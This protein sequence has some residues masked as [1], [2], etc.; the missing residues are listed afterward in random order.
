MFT[1]RCYEFE[2]LEL[3]RFDTFGNDVLASAVATETRK[4]LGRTFGSIFSNPCSFCWVLIDV[5]DIKAGLHGVFGESWWNGGV[6]VAGFRVDSRAASAWRY[7]HTRH[8]LKYHSGAIYSIH[9]SYS[10]HT[11]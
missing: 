7:R 2:E 5:V 10:I 3:S 11:L 1:D 9:V 4:R 8:R 6:T